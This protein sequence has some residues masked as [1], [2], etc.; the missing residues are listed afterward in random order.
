MNCA[1]ATCG[2]TIAYSDSGL[3]DDKNEHQHKMLALYSN[4][5]CVSTRDKSKSKYVIPHKCAANNVCE[6]CKNYSNDNN[7]RNHNNNNSKVMKN[8]KITA[9][10]SMISDKSGN[11][12]IYKLM[13]KP[14]SGEKY[15]KF[16]FGL[17]LD[18]REMPITRERSKSIQINNSKRSINDC[19]GRMQ[20]FNGLSK[21]QCDWYSNRSKNR[22]VIIRIQQMIMQ[23]Q[24]VQLIS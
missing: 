19:N 7:I 15:S 21:Q 17:S 22:L 10:N 3:I 11:E 23:F 1:N 18:E 14:P 13:C 4:S 24:C 16:L 5:D 12:P 20:N 6:T 9:Y 8:N 2:H